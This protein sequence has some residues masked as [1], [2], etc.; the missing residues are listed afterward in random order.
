MFSSALECSDNL[1]IDKCASFLL[2]PLSPSLYISITISWKYD[3]NLFFKTL[4]LWSVDVY[5][6]IQKRQRAKKKLTSWWEKPKWLTFCFLVEGLL[7]RLI[8]IYYCDKSHEGVM[9]YSLQG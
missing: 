5:N 6:K 8:N 3:G 4:K 9:K 7:G 2:S 1:K